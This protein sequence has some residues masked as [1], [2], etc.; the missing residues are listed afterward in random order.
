MRFDFTSYIFVI[1]SLRRKKMR[2]FLTSLGIIIGISSVVIIMSVGKGAESLVVNQIEGIGSDLIAVLPGPADDEGPPA[3][4]MG[5]IIT[6]LTDDDT[7]TI[8]ERVPEIEIAAS[9]LRGVAAVTWQNKTDDTSFLGITANYLEVESTE[10]IKGRFINQE[11][12]D[13]NANVVV[14][15]YSVAEELF[16]INNPLG[17]RVKINKESFRVIGIV[18][19][20]GVVGFQNQDDQVFVPL[21]TAQKL[22]MGVNHISFIRAKARSGSDPAFVIEQTK[23]VLRDQHGIDDPS[24]D[25]FSVRSAEEG[26]DVLKT[27]TGAINYFLAMVA[28]ISLIVGGIGIMNIMLVSVAESTKEIGLRKAVGAKQRDISMQFLMQTI[29][30]TLLGGIIGIII[31]VLI[32]WV[33]AVVATYLGYDWDF[34]VTLDSII[35]ALTFT[36]VVAISFGW[37]PAQKAAKLQ[38]VEALRYE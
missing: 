19:E 29:I 7:K 5:I 10:T 11:E 12:E 18:E 25:D 31:G 30:L 23:Q 38:P 34:I 32:S 16:G 21:S 36:F 37:Y 27:V 33:V 17:E 15:G 35:M 28:A 9:Y 22:L 14:L 20:R 2:S 6:T 26:L 24:E 13:Q 8:I 4:V 1:K 3:S